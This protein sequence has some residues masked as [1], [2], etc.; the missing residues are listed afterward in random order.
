MSI[1]NRKRVVFISLR[2]GLG[3]Q[4]F[5]YFFG[6]YL[7]FVLGIKVIYIY[8]PASNVHHELKSNLSSFKIGNKPI[9]TNSPKIFWHFFRAIFDLPLKDIRKL[10]LKWKYQDFKSELIFYKIY[11]EQFIE[12]KEQFFAIKNWISE[13]NSKT[14]YIR[15]LFQNFK[16]FDLQPQQ[17]LILKNCSNWFQEIKKVII[18]S[19]PAIVHV[20]LGDYLNSHE[21]SLGVLAVDYYAE[22]IKVIRDKF[23]NIEV[24]VFSNQ[25][26][27]AR[28]LL[29]PIIDSGFKF[30]DS[31]DDQDPAEVMLVMSLGKALVVSNSTFSLWS[32][33]LSKT[34]SIIIVPQ[35]FFRTNFIYSA[36]FPKS[37]LRI[38]SSW[39]D[40]PNIKDLL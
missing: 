14:F 29:S 28:I 9:N 3:N 12:L 20:R 27:K 24:W 19:Q 4:L 2:G 38:R 37:W 39:L 15:G 26:E 10:V 32:A 8:H 1:K 5:C 6:E 34:S 11:D 30:V 13:S 18:S 22:A 23:P 21:K 16:Y 17:S 40:K 31:A 25:T 7:N 35:P 33:K 36:S